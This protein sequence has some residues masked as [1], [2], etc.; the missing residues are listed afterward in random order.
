MDGRDT[1]AQA[2]A[3]KKTVV[4]VGM[5][6]AGKTAVGKALATALRVPFRDSDAE[7]ESAANMS[8]AEIFERDGE[9]FFRARETQII[10]RLLDGPPAVLSTGGGA[11]MRAE[12]RDMIT[13]RGVAVWLDAA[14]PVLWNRVRHK[15]TR[16]LLRTPD[17]HATLRDIYE[18]R[19]PVYR[20]ADL[21]VTSE[22]GRSVEDMAARVIEML[23]ARPDVLADEEI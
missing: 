9:P 23:K 15:S 18:A 20:L 12:N 7:I 14:L 5:M 11:Y 3:L 2:L 16:P 17:P 1:R 13:R 21:T 8:I 4:L 6:G 22:T 10:S 19:V